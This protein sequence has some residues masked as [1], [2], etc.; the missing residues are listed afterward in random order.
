VTAAMVTVMPKSAE[1][2]C[3]AFSGRAIEFST[4]QLA[5]IYALRLAQRSAPSILH[6]FSAT[7][8]LEREV[9]YRKDPEFADRR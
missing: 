5:E 3:V 1:G 8:V 6:I 2:W 4:K 7:G 9:V